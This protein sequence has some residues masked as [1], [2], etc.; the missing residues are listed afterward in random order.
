MAESI[1][2]NRTVKVP[3]WPP[4]D[5]HRPIRTISGDYLLT[6][7]ALAELQC[8][9]RAEADETA[10]LTD[11]RSEEYSSD[12]FRMYEFKIR[13]C[14]RSRSHDW[15]ECPY[16]HPGEKARRRDPRKY[17]YSGVGCPNFRKGDCKKGDACEFAH[18]VFE[19]WLH[20][21]RYRTQHCKDGRDCRRRVCFFA[22]RPE[23]L[24][25]PPIQLQ[26]S[27]RSIDSYDGSQ[28]RNRNRNQALD[29]YFSKG[30]TPSSPTS[31]LISP[32]ISSP[33]NSPPVSP[34]GLRM[35]RA[36]INEV[37]LSIGTVHLRKVV[38]HGL[39]SFPASSTAAGSAGG[40]GWLDLES[41]WEKE[42]GVGR[43]ESGRALRAK[44]YERVSKESGVNRP[45][46]ETA[47]Q[48]VPDVGWVSELIM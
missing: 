44:M 35:R 29:L 21:A 36:A 17:Q 30:I 10:E 9:V 14:N 41:D 33:A 7:A 46:N 13:L 11:L 22:H 8:Y 19:C 5:D 47:A 38:G 15:T 37:S 1:L 26:Q 45:E 43:V 2:K 32:P 20:P 3:S 34:N 42:E 12:E 25:V 40:G 6:E 16:A 4:F 24:R 23:Q 31:T 39:C 18:G 27:S 48:A 28:K